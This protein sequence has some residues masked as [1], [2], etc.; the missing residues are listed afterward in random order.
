[1]TSKI[2]ILGS[3]GQMGRASM[4]ALT[5]EPDAID[6]VALGRELDIC[7]HALVASKLKEIKPDIVL[8]TAAFTAVD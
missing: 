4:R 5:R 3:N 1:M 2:L 8:N 7:D 6:V